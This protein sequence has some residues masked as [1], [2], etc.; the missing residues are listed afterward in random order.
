MKGLPYFRWYPADAE[1]DSTYAAMSWEER[2]FYHWCLNY[3]WINNGLPENTKLIAR[4]ARLSPNKFE[5]L[6]GGIS[7]CFTV[8]EGHYRNPRQ[9]VERV[10]ATNKSA[11]AVESIKARYERNTNVSAESYE[12]NTNVLPRALARESESESDKEN[13]QT[14]IAPVGADAPV[15]HLNG[16]GNGH[17]K[18]AKRNTAEIEKALGHRLPW[19]E[20]FWAVYPRHD[21]K[22]AG[23]D[24]FEKRIK[25]HDLAVTVWKGAKQY[26]VRAAAKPDM[27]LAHPA[28]WINGERWL[29][30]ETKP[31]PIPVKSIY[32]QDKPMTKEELREYGI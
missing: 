13:P 26:A 2:G 1:T 16:N 18:S 11:S 14:P 9:E 27:E 4:A 29:D 31:I 22:Q 5:K 8:A 25:D 15:L 30:E 10:H 20:S 32:T 28:T 3:S 24:A 23:M 17:K 19:W 7:K 12:R 21:A 6:W